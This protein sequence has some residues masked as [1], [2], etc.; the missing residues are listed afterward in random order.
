MITVADY[1]NGSEGYTYNYYVR[2][3]AFFFSLYIFFQ[4]RGD[5][6]RCAS[7]TLFNM[8]YWCQL[9]EDV[10][11]EKVVEIVEKLRKGEKPPVRPLTKIYFNTAHVLET[12]T[13]LNYESGFF[14]FS[15]ARKIPYGLGVDLKEGILLC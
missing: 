15:T 10:T 7:E 6:V 12:Y 13:L 14:F 9:Q 4:G 5:V 3:S 2:L 8:P 11:P 1:S